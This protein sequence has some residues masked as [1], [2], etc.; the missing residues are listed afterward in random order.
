MIVGVRTA[1]AP[2][3]F[4]K[5]NE[6]LPLFLLYNLIVLSSSFYA[7]KRIR[8]LIFEK[9]WDIRYEWLRLNNHWYYLLK[10]KLY[11]INAGSK[12]EMLYKKIGFIQID[13]LVRDVDGETVLYSG[14]LENFYLAKD[15]GLD[16]LELIL[17]YRRSFS[18]DQ[19]DKK[20][21]EEA[22]LA[23]NLLDKETDERYYNMPG[24]YFVIPYSQ[25]INLNVT[26]LE[27]TEVEE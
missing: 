17:V 9:D 19:P 4:E 18:K 14:I 3:D 25:V 1:E 8:T 15:D 21:T 13:A 12:D 24:D 22:P 26:Y 20:L 10:G 11:D 5:L 27:F 2:V 7:G 23:T 16:T 6:Q